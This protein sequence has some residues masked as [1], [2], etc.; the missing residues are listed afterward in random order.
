MRRYRILF[1]I[2][3]VLLVVLFS[4]NLYMSGYADRGDAKTLDSITVYTTLPS[5][6]SAVLAGEYE[7]SNKI[8]VH[9][10]HFNQNEL[11]DKMQSKHPDKADVV[12]TDKDVFKKLEGENKLS[13]YT[14]EYTDVVSKRLKDED[15][16]WVGVWY[17][18]IVFCANRDYLRSLS[19]IPLGWQELADDR[20]RLGITD[21]LAADASANLLFTFV[22]EKD[23]QWAFALMKKYHPRIVQYSKYLASPVRMAGMGEVDIAIAVQSETIRYRNEGFPISVIYPREGTAYML[24]GAGVVRGS[25]RKEQ[26]RAFVDWLL[27][28]DVQLALQR[29]KFYFVPA[30]YA[31]I[32]YKT[33]TGK[34]LKLFD[35]YSVLN[36]AERRA[37]LDRWI[38][39]VRFNGL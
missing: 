27:Q 14:S 36:G 18:P 20:S 19:H 28:D 33:Y 38:K 23:E 2:S 11:L 37:V 32:A 10:V 4:G 25:S 30:N 34:E 7:K 8:K 21:F 24:T 5:E 12:M 15:G 6:L 9:F 39:E 31:T 22:A 1:L 16:S 35:E 29:N 3:F 13:K 26:A 17:D